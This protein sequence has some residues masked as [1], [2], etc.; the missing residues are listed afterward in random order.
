MQ[1]SPLHLLR[2][3]PVLAGGVLVSTVQGAPAQG[4]LGVMGGQT[5]EVVAEKLEVDVDRGTALLT[6]RVQAKLGEVQVECPKVEVRYDSAPNVKFARGTG[7]IKAVFRDIT[8]KA[9]NVEVD[10]AKRQ[11][12]LSG[13]VE[14]A[15]GRGWVRAERATIDLSSHKV[16]FDT[17]SGSIPVQPPSR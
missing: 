10:V 9:Q 5:L 6:G 11:M 7:G 17:V 4:P 13:G 2:L 14:L 15:R 3:V 16:S 8:A 1:R 12:T